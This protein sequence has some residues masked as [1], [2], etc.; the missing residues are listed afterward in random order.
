MFKHYIVTRFNLKMGWSTDKQG[1]ELL[2]KQWME[3]RFRLFTKYCVPSVLHQVNPNFQWL[4]YFDTD[5]DNFYKK[6][7]EKLSFK[8]P[9]FKARYVDHHDF[10][11]K[12]L[13]TYIRTKQKQGQTHLITTRLDSD[14]LL[15]EGAV[16]KIQ[17]LFAHQNCQI[18]NFQTGIRFQLEPTIQLAQYEWKS[19]PFLSV[20]EKLNPDKKILTGYAQRHDFYIKDYDIL[21]ITEQPYWTQLIHDGNHSSYLKGK[22]LSDLNRLKP[23][24]VD[25]T[26]LKISSSSLLKGRCFE[27]LKKVTPEIIKTKLR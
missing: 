25:I 21:Q 26:R 23:F 18:I 3:D 6:K 15:H 8:F 7:I 5:T 2:G 4:V 10:F 1:V 19:G 22:Y 24:Q 17:S 16:E 11:L 20:I 9:K 13:E 27:I 12:D 14:D